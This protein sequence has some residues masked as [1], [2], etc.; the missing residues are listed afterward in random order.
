MTNNNQEIVSTEDRK[1]FHNIAKEI[2]NNIDKYLETGKW[3]DKYCS[4]DA[5]WQ[6]QEDKPHK[7]GRDS[8]FR[9]Y[10]EAWKAQSLEQKIREKRT[11]ALIIRFQEACDY[12]L[13]K[14]KGEQFIPEEDAKRIILI[15]WLLTDP[16][17]EKSN[18]N[19]TQLE[20]WSWEP[21]NDISKMTRGYA[22]FL[23]SEG[24]RVYDS[25]MKLVRIAWAKTSAQ[26]EHKASS[27]E[28][29]RI[30]GDAWTLFG[31]PI[32]FRNLLSRVRK[33]KPWIRRISYLGLIILIFAVI[34]FYTRSLWRPLIG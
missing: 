12:L 3:L 23:W 24:G 2:R 5:Y 13:E 20:E 22:Q 10:W 7:I 30:L 14:Y 9:T 18:L 27:P 1:L 21:I 28:S 6:R 31:I 34:A 4:E 19:I 29:N 25:W 8:S 33:L 16:D 15:T 32:H 17:A 11:P 26:I